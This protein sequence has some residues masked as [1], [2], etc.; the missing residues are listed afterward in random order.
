MQRVQSKIDNNIG[1]FL[2]VA[3][4]I[5]GQCERI[6]EVDPSDYFRARRRSQRSVVGEV[7]VDSR[8]IR[9]DN[10]FDY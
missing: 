7:I 9:N 10:R 3:Y 1:D 4:L 6:L 5:V 2:F 8:S